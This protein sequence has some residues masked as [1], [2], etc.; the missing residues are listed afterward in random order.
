M[1]N[2]LDDM[3]SFAGTW[4]EDDDAFS[5][6]INL[7][8]K[9]LL[10]R[11]AVA[12]QA[13]RANPALLRG[14]AGAIEA[15]RGDDVMFGL[16]SGSTPIAANASATITT[17]PQKRNIPKRISV[18]STVADNFVLSDIRV[19]VEPV[20]ATTSNMSLAAFQQDATVPDFR[21]VVCEVGMTFS[22][23]VSNISGAG[24][25]FICTVFGTYVPH[26]L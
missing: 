16:D 6:R 22:L 12:R 20:L 2:Y 23:T 11:K 21:A 1:S 14:G 13:Q 7:Q 15:A 24:A 3:D 9:N 5:G 25:R 17:Q 4:A 26:G 18:S 19:G 10:A 8:L